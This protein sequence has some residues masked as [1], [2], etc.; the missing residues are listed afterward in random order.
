MSYDYAMAN[1][2][3][4]GP[5]APLQWLEQIIQTFHSSVPS[6][7]HSKLLLGLNWYGYKY[8]PQFEGP[9][10]PQSFLNSD[11]LQALENDG[12]NYQWVWDE[13]TQEHRL[14]HSQT[15]A[16]IYYPSLY[17]IAKRLELAKEY[18]TGISIWELGQGLE[19]FCEL[20]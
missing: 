16:Q 15:S 13:T 1:I 6:K 19:Y 11:L 20:L 4:A 2:R 7:Y 3:D 12:E 18:G 10:Q 9:P 5:N 8:E 14:E 17:S